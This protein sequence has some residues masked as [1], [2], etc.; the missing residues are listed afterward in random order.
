M[1]PIETA[2]V[3]LIGI[4]IF[5]FVVIM[6]GMIIILFALKKS[7]DRVNHI[8]GNVEN[9]TDNFGST[10]KAAASGLAMLS[11]KVATNQISKILGRKKSK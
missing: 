8:L 3:V 1:S 2:L 6:I 5:I 11:G 4:Q 7:V 10:L 9:M